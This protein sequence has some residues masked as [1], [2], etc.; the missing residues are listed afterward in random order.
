MRVASWNVRSL[1]DGRGA[2]GAALADLQADVVLVQEAPRLVLWRLS[3]RLLA[4]RAGLRVA[5]SGRAAGNLVLVGPDVRVL[6]SYDVA[7][8]RRPGLH[9]R[10]VAVARVVVDGVT[11][12]VAGTHLD[13]DADAR[14]DSAARVRACLPAGLLVL[15]ADV[16]EQPGARAWTLLGAGLVDVRA[17]LG[18]TFPARAPARSIDGLWASPS[19]AVLAARVVATGAASDHLALVADLGQ[20]PE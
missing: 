9:R 8:P 16:N 11:V 18:P 2:V 10:A 13:L 3:R 7:M 1:R 17:G 14:L 19:L 20:A 5:T 4:R 6:S 12:M 15:G